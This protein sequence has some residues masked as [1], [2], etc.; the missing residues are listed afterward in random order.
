MFKSVIKF[1]RQKKE[2]LSEVAYMHKKALLH[3]RDL[4]V[5]Q[6]NIKKIKR[7]DIILFAV[8]KNEAHR[9]KFFIDYYRRLGV[10]HFILVDNGSTDHFEEVVAG[11]SDISTFYTT[12]SYKNSNFGMYWANY[13][14]LRYGCGHW[15]LTCD[16][17]EFLIYPYMETR[18]LRDLT[19]YLDSL[20]ESA[21][22]TTMIDMYSDKAVEQSY[23]REGH[24]PL[25]ICPY[26][27]ATGYSKSYNSK[28]RNT[29]VQ[30]GVRRRVL[31]P[32]NPVQAPA[33]NK[34]PLI[35]WR[36]H[37]AY[38]ESM[39]MAIP[40]R[41]N[42]ACYKSKTSGALLHFKFI[43]QLVDKIEEEQVAQQHWDNSSEYQ[44][45]GEAIKTKT[46][47]YEPSVSSRF[48]NWQTLA[49]NGLLNVGE[50]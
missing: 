24:N 46:I 9:L 10:N 31:Y 34:V 38:V 6:N 5:R 30:G 43:S 3:A 2:W 7:K 25:D 4:H 22:F 11:Q 16:P 47:L 13:L 33:L 39:H 50:W 29:F 14:L 1:L 23:C 44:K 35:K 21:F 19:E 28:Y 26:F 37:F 8:M 18:D 20:K 45:Y 12:A 40:R 41:L 48:E 42:Q 17:D 36:F 15:C 32:D 49:K 27:D